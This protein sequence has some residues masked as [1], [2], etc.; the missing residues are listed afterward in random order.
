GGGQPVSME[1]IKQTKYICMK[2]DIPLFMDACRFAENAWFIKMREP[3]YENLPIK[4]IVQEI[5]SYADGCTMSAKKDA[6]V[7]MGGWLAMNNPVWAEAARNLLILT[8]GFPTY[9]GLAG[10]D[11]EAIATGLTE[12]IDEDYLHYRISSTQYL[13]SH[14]TAAGIPIVKPAGGHAVYIDARNMLPHITPLQYPGQALA[15]ELY[16]HA[17][18]RACEIGT[19]MFGMQA[20]G[21]EQAAPM[22][23]VRLA[24]PRRVYTQSHIDYVIEALT[25][26]NQN[27]Q[28]LSGLKIVWQPKQ[29]RH[30]SARFLP[31]DAQEKQKENFVKAFAVSQ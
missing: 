9:G 31:L 10:R 5:F 18:I 19:V 3:G 17:G 14:L 20:N 22:D 6:L 24:I 4:T 11:L 15:V 8:E 28:D 23:L 29:L 16:L 2:Y 21:Q 27:K 1:N 26:I 25:E 7:N 30:F 12:V 13:A